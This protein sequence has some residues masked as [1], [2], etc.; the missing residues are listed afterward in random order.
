MYDVRAKF[1]IYNLL[2]FEK[3][4]KRK[5]KQFDAE[6]AGTKIAVTEIAGAE[7]ANSSAELADAQ[8]AAP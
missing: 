3:K 8:T 5:E 1:D 6:T 4:L 2:L 7:M